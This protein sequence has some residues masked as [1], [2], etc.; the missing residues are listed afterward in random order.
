[1][2]AI[3][4]AAPNE[5]GLSRDFDRTFRVA[6]VLKGLDGALEVVGGVVLLFVQPSTLNRIA[7]SVTQ[8]ELSQ[9]RHDYLAT[10]LLHATG[11]LSRSATVF[12]AIYLLSHGLAKLV[13]VVE[14]LRDR[15]W[16]YPA[17]IVLLLAFI[18]YQL[19][20]ILIRATVALVLLTVFD[21]LVTWLTWREYQAKRDRHTS[22]AVR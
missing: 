15:L 21:A 19:Y 1:V 13:L 6:I 3:P 20:R 2:V 4:R 10:H 16:A 7:H 8:H 11:H 12:A 17:M 18:A 14:I 5:H 22:T 9:D